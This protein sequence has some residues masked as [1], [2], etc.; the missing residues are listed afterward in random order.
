VGIGLN[1]KKIPEMNILITLDEET[2]L[3]KTCLSPMAS[4]G[5]NPTLE[6][7]APIFENELEFKGTEMVALEIRDHLIGLLV[8]EKAPTQL[9][10]EILI[11]FSRQ[12]ALTIEN[13]KLFS[14]VEEMA[15]RDILTGLYNRR[16]FHQI[17]DYELNRSK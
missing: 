15:I 1:E 14:K 3:L 5:P 16:Y 7:L 10:Q 4:I 11:I 17:L 13:V 2:E 8:Y 6:R 12:A 9:Q